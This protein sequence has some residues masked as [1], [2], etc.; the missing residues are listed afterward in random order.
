M[1]IITM[2][3]EEIRESYFYDATEDRESFPNRPR[4]R[5]WR[6][7]LPGLRR[8]LRSRAPHDAFA[9]RRQRLRLAGPWRRPCGLRRPRRAAG[10]GPHEPHQ[11]DRPPM[12]G[13]PPTPPKLAGAAR[14]ARVAR[15]G[16][17][18]R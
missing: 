15:H 6:R 2:R 9:S 3:V 17:L 8:L 14:G 18:G 16:T 11:L 10:L 1:T 4:L 12:G 5:L 7:P 13:F